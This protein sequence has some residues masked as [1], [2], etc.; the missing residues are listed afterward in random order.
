MK[1]VIFV[2]LIFIPVI[3]F[4]QSP[5][6]PGQRDFQWP[7]YNFSYNAVPDSLKNEDAVILNEQLTVTDSKIRRRVVVKIQTEAAL[8]E[9]KIIQ[10]PENFDLTNSPNWYLQGRFK[11][12]KDPFIYAFKIS[13]FAARV[14][15]PNK[16]HNEQP[17]KFKSEKVCWIDWDGTRV[18]DYLHNFDIEELEVG[19]IL[20]YTY[21]ANVDWNFNQNVIHPNSKYPKLNYDLE[22]KAGIRADIK[23]IEL[24]YNYKMPPASFKKTIQNKNGDQVHCFTYH[25]DYLKGYNTINYIRSGSTLPSISVNHGRYSTISSSNSNNFVYAF[26]KYKWRLFIDTTKTSLFDKYH[27]NIRKFLSAFP[28]DPSDTSGNGFMTMLVDT[29]NK[30]KFITTE[31]MKYGDIPQ[32]ALPSSEQLV[33]GRMTEEFVIKNYSDFLS[34]REIYYYKGIIIDKRKGVINPEYRNQASLERNLIVVPE[35][36]AFKYYIPRHR[37]VTYLPD[38]LPFYFENTS[39]ALMPCSHCNRKNE[40]LQLSFIIIPKSSFNQNTRSESGSIKISTDSLKMNLFIKENLSGQFSTL[41]RH[42]Y[43]NGFR[44]F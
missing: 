1:R 16:K 34:E 7:D 6:F 15:K 37:G 5:A 20:D 38:E 23:N 42:Y 31:S 39:C 19:D 30:L 21:E 13:Y 4:S 27:A 29:L 26:D 18:Y 9:F 17:L 28:V 3:M 41:L 44:L 12:R 25:F 11:G 10:L 43:N 14:I 35:K 22:V 32:Y 33:K 8:Q 40:K 36:R 24:V 2:I